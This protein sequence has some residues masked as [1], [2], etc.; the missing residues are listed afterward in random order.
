MPPSKKTKAPTFFKKK[1]KWTPKPTTWCGKG[2]LIFEWNVGRS[3]KLPA[4]VTFTRAGT[5]RVRDRNGKWWTAATNVPRFM[6]FDIAD[7]LG[8]GNLVYSGK[9]GFILLEPSRTNLINNNNTGAAV[10]TFPT[11]WGEDVG[12]A[13]M[14]LTIVG[15]GAAD[16]DLGLPYIDVRLA[17]TMTTAPKTHNLVFAKSGSYIAI[18]KNSPYVISY[19]VKHIS[20]EMPAG[21]G[22]GVAN[23]EASSTTAN[24]AGTYT[25]TGL[26]HVPTSQWKR[27][28]QPETP[29]ASTAVRLKPFAEY[30]IPSN[31]VYDVVLRFSCAM[32]HRYGTVPASPIINGTTNGVSLAETLNLTGSTGWSSTNQMRRIMTSSDTATLQDRT[33]RFLNDEDNWSGNATDSGNQTFRAWTPGQRPAA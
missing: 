33:L 24:I 30:Y 32:V 3:P 25:P 26:I 31:A 9:G 21:F 8:D 2:T 4:G 16:P 23:V 14:A 5:G 1:A 18:T 10:G 20:G 27:L 29:T 12:Q 17:G 19:Y 28:W 6:D 7:P 11:R 15:L 13:G 22:L